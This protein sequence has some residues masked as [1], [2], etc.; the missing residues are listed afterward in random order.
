VTGGAAGVVAVVTFVL[1]IAGVLGFGLPVV[2]A[3]VSAVCIWLFRR[4][5]GSRR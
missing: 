4:T 2:A 3:I 1:A 5:V